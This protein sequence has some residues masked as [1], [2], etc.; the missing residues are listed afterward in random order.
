MPMK[1]MEPDRREWLAAGVPAGPP[2]YTSFPAP[3][4]LSN[5]VGAA[6]YARGLSRIDP[7]AP[8]S[9]GVNVP[10]CR[11]V[12]CQCGS[13]LRVEN[14]YDGV[15]DYVACV[16]AEIEIVGRHL[17]GRGRPSSVHFG[18]DAPNYL[19]TDELSAILTAIETH[20]G[21]P[22]AARLS[23]DLD[24][25][26]LRDSDPDDL[27]ALGFRRMSFRIQDFDF[28]VQA[29]IGCIQS[30][31]LIEAGVG[32]VRAAGVSDLSFAL[33]CGLPRQTR[34]SFE[35]TLVK[36][37]TLSPDR[38][39]LSSYFKGDDADGE[40]S[41][42]IGCV[43]DTRLRAEFVDLADELLISEGYF[44][45]GFDQYAK[46]DSPIV[47]AQR[48]GRFRRSLQGWSEDVADTTI[49]FGASAT[50]FIDGV[51]VQ[52]IEGLRGYARRV[53]S[54][55]LATGQGIRLTPVQMAAGSTIMSLLCGD[56]VDP[57]DI[58][59]A[60]APIAFAAALSRLD[61]LEGDGIVA[62]TGDALAHSPGGHVLAG[63]VAMALGLD[64][65][66]GRRGDFPSAN[67]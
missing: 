13:D 16:A 1:P 30:F 26:L 11:Q 64:R 51:Y 58:R 66:N 2:R 17:D 32:A 36:T 39:S 37:A 27:V 29:A 52:N 48:A 63:V 59:A 28:D 12:C 23:I 38:V 35:E 15:L 40:Q 55:S 47:A 8:L 10:F 24:P 4:P 3:L 34:R 61:D 67:P 54:G 5:A 31:D 53:R 45:I 7:N 18:G 21:L 25:R 44:R 9:L 33:V 42:F 22:D 60:L 57:S 46:S 20:I 41:S 19:L 14:D 43:P 56:E 62:R 50:G 6:D 65:A 49:A